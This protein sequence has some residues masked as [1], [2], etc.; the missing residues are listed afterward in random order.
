MITIN[1]ILINIYSFLELNW[2]YQGPGG[3]FIFPEDWSLYEAAIP[4]EERGNYMEA[5]GKRLRGEMGEEGNL[6]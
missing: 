3:S 4:L 2:M 5:Y 1:F 6:I